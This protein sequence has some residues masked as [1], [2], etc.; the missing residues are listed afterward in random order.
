MMKPG[1]FQPGRIPREP[2]RRCRPDDQN[3]TPLLN[4]L[5][6]ASDQDADDISP[7]P[8]NRMQDSPS[9]SARHVCEASDATAAIHQV[10]LRC[11]DTRPAATWWLLLLAILTPQSA[12]VAEVCLQNLERHRLVHPVVLLENLLAVE[13]GE[14]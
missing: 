11:G 13:A 3:S 2:R 10:V 14:V 1:L 9:R 7:R 5:R 6:L 4:V 12:S 8:T